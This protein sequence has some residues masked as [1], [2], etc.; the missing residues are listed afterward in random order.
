MPKPQQPLKALILSQPLPR[1]VLDEEAAHSSALRYE[2]GVR[3]YWRCLM[4]LALADRAPNLG[5]M[6]SSVPICVV[7]RNTIRLMEVKA[8]R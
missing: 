4:L 1:R 8:G 6:R 3:L 2:T 5:H 7:L